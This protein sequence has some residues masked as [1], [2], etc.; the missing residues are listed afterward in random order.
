MNER[1]LNKVTAVVENLGNVKDIAANMV[2]ESYHAAKDLST[3]TLKEEYSAFW[4]QFLY[5]NL[6]RPSATERQGI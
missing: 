4:R 2:H 6:R 3:Y 1:T 5:E